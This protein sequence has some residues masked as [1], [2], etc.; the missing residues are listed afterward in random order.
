MS[1][2]NFSLLEAVE[3]ALTMEEEGIRF[4][5]LA[6]ERTGEPEMKKFFVFLRDMEHKHIETFRRLYSGLAEREGTPDAELW[7]LDGAVAT[8]FRAQVESTVFPTKGSAEA[9]VAG[10]HGV[11]DLLGFALRVEK[12]SILFYQELLAHAPWP[13]AKELIEKVVAEERRHLVFVRE[14]LAAL[15]G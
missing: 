9:A 8:Y 13:E 4:Y 5:T 15:G 12:D 2:R 7:L 10:L 1:M 11:V 14:K 6:E 3:V